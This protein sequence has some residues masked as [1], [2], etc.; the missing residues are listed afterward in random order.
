M[1]GGAGYS[2][3]NTIQPIDNGGDPMLHFIIGFTPQYKLSN[4]I[5]LFADVSTIFHHFQ[6]TTFD[7]APH[8]SPKET[9]VGIFNASLGLN[10]SLGNSR[11]QHA[12]FY[13]PVV[14]KNEMVDKELEAI[15]K[16]LDSA[17]QEIA[18]LKNKTAAPNQ[19]LILTGILLFL[20]R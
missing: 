8:P 13:R 6:N 19:E 4:R 9:N 18:K 15:K 17:E 16:R 5:S 11:K 7:G 12:D 10:V 14:E 20:F 1:H 3:L 2:T